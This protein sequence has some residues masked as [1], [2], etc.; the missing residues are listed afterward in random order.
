MKKYLNLENISKLLIIIVLAQLLTNS[1]D[2]I[3]GILLSIC[4]I[5]YIKRNGYKKS[6]LEL[7]IGVYLIGCAL[8]LPNA[9][10]FKS[11]LKELYRHLYGFLLI[12]TVTQIPLKEKI[13]NRM[14][15]IVMGVLTIYYFIYVNLQILGKVPLA[16]PGNRYI[17]F[18]DG[19]IVKYAFI[20]GVVGIYYLW[21]MFKEDNLKYKICLLVLYII[22]GYLLLVSQTRGAWLGFVGGTVIAIFLMIKNKKRLLYMGFIGLIILFGGGYL[23]RNNEVVNRYYSRIESIGN[24]K[25]DLSNIARL[26]AWKDAISKFEK[27]PIFGYGYKPRVTYKTYVINDL[28]HPHNDYLNILVGSGIIGLLGYIFMLYYIIKEELKNKEYL[29]IGI[30]SYVIIYGNFEVIIQTTNCLF[31]ILFICVLKF[32]F[33][34]K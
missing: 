7:P 14:I 8:S 21:Q 34:K 11:S 16:I 12:F 9:I 23:N 26:N 31:L 3:Y 32:K 15:N 25:T 22:N 6:G 24:T 27:R 29:L 30:F 18:H 13:K 5:I 10:I 17:G 28:D 2:R 33:H 19:N 20:I 4:G 1:Y